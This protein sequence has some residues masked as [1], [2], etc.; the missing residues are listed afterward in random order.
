MAG[1][2]DPSAVPWS[3]RRV[4]PWDD[5]E[6]LD[7][8]QSGN[9]SFGVVFVASWKSSRVAVKIYKID[10]VHMSTYDAALENLQREAGS[11]EK[12]SANNLNLNEHIVKF[13]GVAG[14]KPTKAWLDK[15]GRLP[16]IDERSGSM[17]AL[18]M[19][20]EGGGNLRDML[21]A[22]KPC[23]IPM[24]ERLRILTEVAT[25]LFYL[26]R[27]EGEAIIHGDIKPE[28]VL[29]S[30]KREV[31][32]ADF[33][34]SKVR[35]LVFGADGASRKSSVVM[36]GGGGGTWPYMAPELYEDVS[37]TR[38]TD[39]YSFGTLCW[40]VLSGLEPWAG[41]N[42]S[43]R[44][45][46]IH[47]GKS[48]DFGA[49]PRNTP[50]SVVDMIRACLAFGE[51]DDSREGR[52][53]RP[54]I[55]AVRDT[56]EQALNVFEGGKFS[57]FLSYCWGPGH[58]RQPLT[59]QVYAQLRDAGFRVWMDVCDMGHNLVS[60]MKEGIDNS[61]CVVVLL[62][63]DY[64][65]S[66]A[67][68]FELKYASESGKPI[69]VC[70]VEPGFWRAWRNADGS[71]TIDPNG[72]VAVCARLEQQ[73][74]VDL[75]EA[76]KVDWKDID[77]VSEADRRKLNELPVAMPRLRQ[78]LG[79]WGIASLSGYK[80]SGSGSVSIT[81]PPPPPP[82]RSLPLPTAEALTA[83]D[84]LAKY[85]RV[86]SEELIADNRAKTAPASVGLAI[87]EATRKGDA[88]A[89]LELVEQWFANS[90]LNEH[91]GET[92]EWTALTVAADKGHTECIRVLAAQPGID[93]NKSSRSNEY[94]PLLI[95]SYGGH[96][97]AVEVLCSLPGVL[98]DQP[99][100]GGWTPSSH[101]CDWYRGA[102]KEARTARIRAL[103]EAKGKVAI[104]SAPPAPP[105]PHPAPGLV[106]RC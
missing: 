8:I 18:V 59:Q 81:S 51:D 58:V 96:V 105:K 30:A 76:S 98:L 72:E 25:G 75:A 38:S 70:M 68:C 84:P 14:G 26:H 11:L 46:E 7:A 101:A 94:T 42:E 48:L 17:I 32:L 45:L 60:S 54:S 85:K 33:G 92:G 83:A 43:R 74:F 27:A 39:M 69:I 40:E 103:L 22:V 106:T 64:V 2:T 19:R 89:L 41:F 77:A 1:Q 4:I 56:M 29:F 104:A 82:V 61:E 88:D 23:V 65:R 86:Y 12:A 3:A 5:I 90:V 50:P 49:I 6:P 102:D 9:G 80:R 78:L 35:Q 44:L 97:E 15:I 66:R 24:L 79:E 95:A 34:L 47:K 63:P 28:N 91:G 55:K 62:S 93:I 21:H 13:H 31:R 37:I 20:F 99:N 67:C 16:V 73:M 71:V 52:G 10:S 36:G 53:S 87:F 57:V 100:R